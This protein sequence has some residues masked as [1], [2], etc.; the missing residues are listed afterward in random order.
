MQSEAGISAGHRTRKRADMSSYFFD[1]GLVLRDGRTNRL[2]AYNESAALVWQLLARTGN[3]GDASEVISR[4]YGIPAES[5]SRDVAEIVGHW[6]S[7]GLLHG[8]IKRRK[9]ET[10]PFAPEA[11]TAPMPAKNA[12]RGTYRIRGCAFAITIED[13]AVAER[14]D[15]LLRAYRADYSG[16][17]RNVEVLSK[18]SGDLILQF[19]GIETVRTNSSAEMTGALFQA[20]LSGIHSYDQWLA[21]IHGGAV[22]LNGHGVLIPG[23]SGSGKSTLGAFLVARG[24]DYLSDDMIAVTRAGQIAAWPIPLSIKQGSW[25]P[26]SP[27]LPQLESI[28]PVQVWDRVVKYVTVPSASW[29]VPDCRASIFVFPR[30]HAAAKETR[31]TPLRPLESLRR[32]ISD[33]IWLGYPLRA[34]PIEEFL[35]WLGQ[36]RSYE[37]SYGSFEG[38]EESLRKILERGHD[39]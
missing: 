1:S 32:L 10:V 34:R 18:P 19:D 11:A 28:E 12:M 16:N 5:A 23:A 27:Y 25:K 3:P 14:A 39:T 36:M 33:R 13:P 35:N 29:D 21:I 6:R 24:F 37:L 38:I 26:L 20:L 8:G 17:A 2:F 4:T 22:A 31:L 9:R 30:F 7:L 15:S